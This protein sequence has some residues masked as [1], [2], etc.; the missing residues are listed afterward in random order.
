MTDLR[1]ATAERP[2]T[3]SIADA[4]DEVW[5]EKAMRQS[6][7]KRKMLVWVARLAVLAVIIG[8]W[9][10]A[11]GRLINAFFTSS[12]TAIAARL[13]E[14]ILDGTVLTNLLFTVQAMV[15]GFVI[16]SLSGIVVGFV[17]GRIPFLAQV[18]DPLIVSVYSLPK[19]AL[20]PLF[21]LWF[22]IGL[23]SKVV[24]AAVIVFFFLFYNTYSGVREVDRELVD[25]VRLMGGTRRH[26]LTKVV[27]PSAATWIFAGLRLAVPYSL[28][29]AVVGEIVASNRGLG[30]LLKR[31]SGV[32]DTAGVFASLVILMVIATVLNMAVNQFER[33]TSRWNQ[34]IN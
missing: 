13:W 14:W 33:R 7:R 18:L 2:I 17:L 9:Q 23:L 19:I 31:S 1:A 29:G 5:D 11:A 15:L 27:L 24:L 8:F 30:Y 28:I 16:G 26:I 12:P 3:G 34:A 32:F 20:A 4:D 6:A 22:G 10:F 21:I 25:V